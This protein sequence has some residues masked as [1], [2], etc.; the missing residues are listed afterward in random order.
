MDNAGGKKKPPQVVEKIMS[1]KLEKF[2]E[3]ACLMEQPFIK[4]PNTKIKDLLVSLVSK[5]GENM[6]IR[7]FVRYLL[8]EEEADI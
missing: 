1:G 3:E 6:S 4:D 2:Y 5:T 8:G 7:R